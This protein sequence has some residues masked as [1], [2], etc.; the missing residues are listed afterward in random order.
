MSQEF[1]SNALEHT[2]SK[3]PLH[4]SRGYEAYCLGNLNE[5]ASFY[6]SALHVDPKN[7]D[8]L[9][10]LAD[11]SVK[12]KN[13]PLAV[14]YLYRLL[15]IDRNSAGVYNTLGYV[16]K[17]LNRLE[18]ALT[19]YFLVISVTPDFP[20]AYLSCGDILFALKR[21]D[22]AVGIYDKAIALKPNYFEAFNNRGVALKELK[23]LDEA[24]ASY[25][26]AI[27]LRPD[28]YEAYN[29]RGDALIASKRLDEAVL[30]INQA[31]AIKPDYFKAYNNRGN[32]LIELKKLDEA[33]HS[34]TQA[35]L[36]EPTNPRVNF[37]LGLYHLLKANFKDGWVGYEA[38]LMDP[39]SSVFTRNR[40]FKKPIWNG[41]DDLRGKTIFIYAEQGLGDTIQFSRYIA[42]VAKE[43]AS[44]IFEVQK[45]IL[46][47]LS[48]LDGV[49][50]ILAKGDEVPPFDYQ[51]PLLSLPAL[52]KTELTNI[53]PI[54][55]PLLVPE[56]KLNEWVI[57]LGK[58]VKPRIGLVWSGS[59]IHKKDHFRSLNL[60]ELIHLLPPQFEY[61]SLQK[62]IS[63]LDE[64]LLRKNQ[65]KHFGTELNDFTDTAA[66]TQLMDLVIS[67]DTSVAHLAA[68]LSI[69]TWILI[70]YSPDW[71]WLLDRTDSPWYPSVKLYRQT[72]LNSWDTALKQVK[73]DLEKLA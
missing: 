53:P 12:L 36:I 59:T 16:L 10:Y 62:E 14:S 5:A 29:N 52:F 41:K 56:N 71:R 48:S 27:E 55:R 15:E 54:V 35:A 31:I 45:S 3:L 25:S 9:K 44:V 24:I 2:N 20:D 65:I 43:G 34:Y 50:T 26:K 40:S 73:L 23:K 51:C 61:I 11:I 37:N 22:E 13:Y 19:S 63:S 68:T 66:L 17:Q 33:F 32:A 57:R 46:K 38:R 64:D 58:R 1:P 39:D 30:S 72:E 67:V 28:A 21:Y 18:E 49:T 69:P 70:A 8:A 60:S 47:L 42:E 7:W 4:L 6:N